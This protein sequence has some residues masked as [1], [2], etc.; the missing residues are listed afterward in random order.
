MPS[1]N[2]SVQDNSAGVFGFGDAFGFSI[3][4]LLLVA[5]GFTRRVPDFTVPLCSHG[6]VKNVP[7]IGIIVYSC[8][9]SD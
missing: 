3:F 6:F 1:P 9:P 4:V 8:H 5:L 2:N 7:T